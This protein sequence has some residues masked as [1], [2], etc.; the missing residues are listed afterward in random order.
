MVE[1]SRRC[2][3]RHPPR[4][5]RAPQRAF[6]ATAVVASGAAKHALLEPGHSLRRFNAVGSQV[7]VCPAFAGVRRYFRF[8]TVA[9]LSLHIRKFPRFRYNYI[10]CDQ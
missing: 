9:L 6:G 3:L 7:I 10:A 4:N 2:H 5:V 8:P 1:D